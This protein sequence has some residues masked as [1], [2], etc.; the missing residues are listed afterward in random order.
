MKKLA[1]LFLTASLVFSMTTVAFAAGSKST[2]VSYGKTDEGA[3]VI[4]I[5]TTTDEAKTAGIVVTETGKAEISE[6]KKEDIAAAIQVA[7]AN[8]ELDITGEVSAEDVQILDVFDV[9][10]PEDHT[11]GTPVDITIPG[12]TY[13]EGIVVLHFEDGVWVALPTKEGPNNTVVATFTNF[14][15][16]AIALVSATEATT[17]EGGDAEA[18]G[19][20]TGT[21]EEKPEPTSGK[22][23]K[24]ADANT[25]LYVTLLALAAGATAYATKRKFA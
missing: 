7:I 23:P 22:S 21:E 11:P 14:S 1:G 6:D 20:T 24:T 10:A 19:E 18:E 25:V 3:N 13:Q 8:D 4:E 12:V 2:T 16:T 15:P 5:D 17:P 9:E